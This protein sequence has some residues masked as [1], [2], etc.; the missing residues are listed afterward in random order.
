MS[1]TPQ[2]SDLEHGVARKSRV[3]LPG[4]SGEVMLILGDGRSFLL[5]ECMIR[6]HPYCVD[7]EARFTKYFD[8][9][10]T[11]L[12]GYTIQHLDQKIFE[13][14]ARLAV[15]R[16]NCLDFDIKLSPDEI[17]LLQKEELSKF[18]KIADYIESKRGLFSRGEAVFSGRLKTIELVSELRESFSSL[19]EKIDPQHLIDMLEVGKVKELVVKNWGSKVENSVML[20]VDKFVD[21][22]FQR[23]S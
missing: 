20:F 7:P 13:D 14:K 23:R 10:Y 12:C 2:A 11:L 17:L 5:S 6:D 21:K 15:F 18:Q 9:I 8:D 22:F 3:D 1:R 19:Y 16:T 4:S